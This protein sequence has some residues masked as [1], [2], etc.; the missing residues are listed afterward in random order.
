MGALE[1]AA[2]G[3]RAQRQVVDEAGACDLAKTRELPLA[4][5]SSRLARCGIGSGQRVLRPPRVCD[6][7]GWPGECSVRYQPR[8]VSPTRALPFLVP[9]ACVP[10]AAERDSPTSTLI[11]SALLH[12]NHMPSLTCP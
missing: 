2:A 10:M 7:C 8:P 4:E 6:S 5:A 3:H 11:Y 12:A 1:G 9:G